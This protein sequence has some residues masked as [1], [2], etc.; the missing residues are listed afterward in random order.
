MQVHSGYGLF[1]DRL[2]SCSILRFVPILP[3]IPS[4]KGC[5]KIIDINE[6]LIHLLSLSDI[7][8]AEEFQKEFLFYWNQAAED[9]GICKLYIGKEREFQKLNAYKSNDGAV[10]FV[11]NG[12]CLNDANKKVNG[13]KKWRHL[14]ELPVFYIPITDKRRV[15]PPTRDKKWTAENIVMLIYGKQFNR[16][17]HESYVKL[18]LEKI[19]TNRELMDAIGTLGWHTGGEENE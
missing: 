14:P 7:E 17:S 16:I 3:Y 13:S 5:K 10:R 19:K 6:K 12:I 4:I 15:L 1:S 8:K 9:T 11:A 18:G 2:F